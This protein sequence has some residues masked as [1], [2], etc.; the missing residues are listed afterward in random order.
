MPTPDRTIRPPTGWCQVN[1]SPRKTTP[2][3]AAT[4]GGKYVTIEP[5]VTPA[6]WTTW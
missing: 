3:I 2:A 1:V 6:V 4:N 5:V